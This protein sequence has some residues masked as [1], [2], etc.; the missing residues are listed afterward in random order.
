MRMKSTTISMNSS[1]QR[2]LHVN[3]NVIPY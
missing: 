2:H 1:V 3:L